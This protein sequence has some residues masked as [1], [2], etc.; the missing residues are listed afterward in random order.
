MTDLNLMTD[1]EWLPIDGLWVIYV[2]TTTENP[3]MLQAFPEVDAYKYITPDN[4]VM[5]GQNFYDLIE[6][7]NGGATPPEEPIKL[8]GQFTEQNRD[9]LLQISQ[10][11]NV[12]WLGEPLVINNAAKEG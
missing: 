7:L 6:A 12:E 5:S 3:S 10:E 9:L 4:S 8:I 2:M 11:Y 1:P